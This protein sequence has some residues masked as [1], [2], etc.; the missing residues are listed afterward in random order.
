MVFTEA[1]EVEGVLFGRLDGAIW[2]LPQ[3]IGQ[4]D[5]PLKRILPKTV[6]NKE[7][8][9]IRQKSLTM[10]QIFSRLYKL[11]EPIAIGEG[12]ELPDS[13]K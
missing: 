9:L 2:R 4:R 7:R 13:L 1:F 12:M 11:P 8:Y 3:K 10:E 6:C 5:Y